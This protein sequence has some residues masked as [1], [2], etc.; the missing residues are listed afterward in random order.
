MS[1]NSPQISLSIVVDPQLHA[2]SMRR[3]YY[4]LAIY[5]VSI[6]YMIHI[7]KTHDIVK[8]IGKIAQWVEQKE[9]KHYLRIISEINENCFCHIWGKFLKWN[10]KFIC[11]T[12]KIWKHKS[13]FLC[14]LSLKTKI[15]R[16]KNKLINYFHKFQNS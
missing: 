11:Q 16:P 13:S 4:S 3:L 12:F 7:R 10:F 5:I 2:R 15:I 9:S 8:I 6:N 1:N 14:K